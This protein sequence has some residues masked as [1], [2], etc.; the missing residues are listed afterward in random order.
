MNAEH[1]MAT[2]DGLGGDPLPPAQRD[3]LDALTQWAVIVSAERLPDGRLR[4]AFAYLGIE[5][6]ITYAAA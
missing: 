1:V 4:V 3:R 6:S 5:Q 2:S